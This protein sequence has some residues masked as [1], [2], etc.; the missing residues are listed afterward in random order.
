M[1]SLMASGLLLLASA[2]CLAKPIQLMAPFAVGTASKNLAQA[3]DVLPAQA[4]SQPV[5]VDAADKATS[6]GLPVLVATIDMA[7]YL[8]TANSVNHDQIKY[9]VTVSTLSRI[10]EFLLIHAIW[11]TRAFQQLIA[12]ANMKPRS[13]NFP[14]EDNGSQ[15]P[16]SGDIFKQMAGIDE[17]QVCYR[18]SDGND[19]HAKFRLTT[20]VCTGL[21]S[22]RGRQSASTDTFTF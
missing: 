14:S 22:Q 20:L 13:L 10:P 9:F 11:P 6:G 12:L 17:S 18:G 7:S 8:G 3:T 21:I 15:T 5:G 4:I 16:F 19:G 1:V 2:Q